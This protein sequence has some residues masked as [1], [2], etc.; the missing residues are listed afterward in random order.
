M[1]NNNNRRRDCREED[2]YYDKATTYDQKLA[3]LLM[4]LMVS[5]VTLGAMIYAWQSDVPLGPAI[6]QRPLAGIGAYADRRHTV[7]SPN[8]DDPNGLG[9]RVWSSDSRSVGRMEA[10]LEHP[11]YLVAAGVNIWF[12][13]KGA[14][15]DEFSYYSW[16][17]SF[18][19]RGLR[20][21][22][23]VQLPGSGGDGSTV[24]V[25]F[26][27]TPAVYEVTVTKASKETGAVEGVL[28]TRVTTH[29]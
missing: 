13:L 6:Q 15:P 27:L 11:P 2:A 28:T 8:P 1:G 14:I 21:T 12:N 19:D 17:V 24:S 5:S 23:P 29:I 25:S 26:P 3:W 22:L 7:D 4:I 9:L 16:D 18:R 10:M 20:L